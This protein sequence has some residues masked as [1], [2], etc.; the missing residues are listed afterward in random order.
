MPR[1]DRVRAA[2]PK[3]CRRAGSRPRG[4]R[5]ARPRAPRAPR[6]GARGRGGAR[7]RSKRRGVGHGARK[8]TGRGASQPGAPARPRGAARPGS[9]AGRARHQA[10]SGAATAFQVRAAAKPARRPPPRARAA[11]SPSRPPIALGERRRARGSHSNAAPARRELPRERPAADRDRRHAA[12]GRVEQTRAVR[13][14]G[15]EPVR[16][17]RDERG[18]TPRR[19]PARAPYGSHG[20]KTI[21]SPAGSISPGALAAPARRRAAA[22]SPGWGSR[23][24][25][26]A[27]RGCR[28]RDRGPRLEER[29][30]VVPV[31]DAAEE[32]EGPRLGHARGARVPAARSPR[33]G[34]SGNAERHDRE[35][36]ARASGRPESSR[37]RCGPRR[38]AR[39]RRRAA[40]R[41]RRTGRS[42]RARARAPASRGRGAPSPRRASARS[43]GSRRE[44]DRRDRRRPGRPGPR[45]TT[46]SRR[47]RRRRRRRRRA[48]PPRARR[49]RRRDDLEGARDL[50]RLG[51]VVGHEQAHVELRRRA[52]ARAR[53]RGSP[54]RPSADGS[55]PGRGR[56]PARRSPPAQP[57]EEEVQLPG[58]RRV[59]LL[60]GSPFTRSIS[61]LRVLRAAGRTPR[62]RS[63]RSSFS[64]RERARPRLARCATPSA[65]SAS[66][67]RRW[68]SRSERSSPC[69]TPSRWYQN[70][71][72][73]RIRSSTRARPASVRRDA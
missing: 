9:D 7:R 32:H 44:T 57:V 4:P 42:P 14:L 63:W 71:T 17:D 53:A 11:G 31:V 43:G 5:G 73:A 47:G 22:S 55:A 8:I 21:D 40:A 41:A 64:P 36:T 38:R 25:A 68:P 67:A 24:R 1:E 65:A 59:D 16:G 35:Q 70:A 58:P 48:R 56:R 13:E 54:C 3:R 12:P 20:E 30:R 2:C 45:G 60:R 49:V 51:G 72:C 15:L 61:R 37:R 46:R 62:S 66:L 23:R 52:P 26:A 18:P 33:A 6:A 29:L 27:R 69:E 34:A 50:A 28:A 10:A 39:P 19:G